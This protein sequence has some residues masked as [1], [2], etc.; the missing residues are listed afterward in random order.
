MP[1][2]CQTVIQLKTLPLRIG[3]LSVGVQVTR[4]LSVPPPFMS[5]GVCM[6]ILCA[7]NRVTTRG[8]E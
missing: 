5:A 8:D 6:C 2:R 7:I 3:R 4:F 1:K